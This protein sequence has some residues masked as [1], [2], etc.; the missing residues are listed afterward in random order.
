MSRAPEPDVRGAARLRRAGAAAARGRPAVGRAA[1]RRAP[2]R[3]RHRR[4]PDAGAGHERA[5]RTRRCRCAGPAWCTTW[6]RARRRPTC[7]RATIGH[8]GAQRDAGRAR[9]PSACACRP[10][11]ASWPTSWRASTAT[12]TAAAT[13]A[14]PRW[15]G[16][17]NAAT[18]CAGRRASTTCCWPANAMRAAAPG[19]EDRPYPPR[20][21]LPPL[22]RRRA[23]G[24][25]RGGRRRRDGDAA[26]KGPAIGDA[27]MA[28]RVAAIAEAIDAASA[29][30]SP[31]QPAAGDP[32]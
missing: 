15:C 3:G 19:C 1:A 20:E 10:T 16:C 26:R 32:D 9:W 29:G 22:L 28:A 13:S 2:P 5:A 23:G 31:S 18:R 6:A 25:H 11:A 30:A 8:E 21:R 12:S 7:C 14:P 27:V 17:S 24:R 4:A